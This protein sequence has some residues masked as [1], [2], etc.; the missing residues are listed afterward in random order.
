MEMQVDQIVFIILFTRVALFFV[1]GMYLLYQWS[2][3]DERILTD[4]P[5]LMA[6]SFIF[7]GLGK[8]FDALLLMTVPAEFDPTGAIPESIAFTF[9]LTK[10]R[11]LFVMLCVVPYI[12]ILGKVWLVGKERYYYPVATLYMGFWGLIIFFAPDYSFLT[13]LVP[14]LVIPLI[15]FG[16]SFLIIYN[17][18]LIHQVNAFLIGLGF[19]L[20]FFSNIGRAVIM[21]SVQ[22]IMDGWFLAELMDLIVYTVLFASFFVKPFYLKSGD[23]IPE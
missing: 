22:N 4:I 21:G 14:F 17:K 1:M 20:I 9:L 3:K 11:M 8:I 15:F 19:L 16:V 23:K 5:F 13:S 7:M 2:K 6:L 18:R 12:I 10:F